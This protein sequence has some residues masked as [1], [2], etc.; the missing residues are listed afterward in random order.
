MTVLSILQRGDPKLRF[1]AHEIPVFPV[2]E[3][4]RQLARDMGETMFHH[5]GIGLAAIQVGRLERLIVVGL[6]RLSRD[7]AFV[8]GLDSA[9]AD[10]IILCNPVIFKK[11]DTQLSREG[12]LSVP[13][14]EWNQSVTRAKRIRVVFRTLNGETSYL[15]A[16][17]NLAAVIQHEIDHLDGILFT[18]Y[19]QTPGGTVR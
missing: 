17:G 14:R 3:S 16:H 18:D 5:N 2:D 7:V 19:L 9:Q 11:A 8:S 1:H 15:K 10:A 4:I 12:C 13:K 6:D